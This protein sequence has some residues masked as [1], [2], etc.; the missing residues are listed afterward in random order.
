MG[1][2]LSAGWLVGA[3]GSGQRSGVQVLALTRLLNHV[4]FLSS[5]ISDLP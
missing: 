5:Q 2:G 3:E 1:P 4:E